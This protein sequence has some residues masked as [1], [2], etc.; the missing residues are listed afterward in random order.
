MKVSAS[1]GAGASGEA[2]ERN[3][4]ILCKQFDGDVDKELALFAFC[5]NRFALI[6]QLSHIPLCALPNSIYFCGT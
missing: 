3:W 5:L 1:A 6:S 2:G 4:C